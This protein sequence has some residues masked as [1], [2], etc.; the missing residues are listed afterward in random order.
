MEGLRWW[1]TFAQL[2]ARGIGSRD[3]PLRLDV[4]RGSY[5]IHGLWF[6]TPH[7]LEDFLPKYKPAAVDVRPSMDVKYAHVADA[8]RAVQKIGAW[9]GIIGY[10]RKVRDD[11]H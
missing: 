5:G 10:E 4:R 6:R 1:F 2:K 9:S 8:M 7:D 11:I 3:K